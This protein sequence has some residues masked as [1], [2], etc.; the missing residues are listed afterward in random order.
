MSRIF[1]RPMFKRGGS[2]GQGITSGLAPTQRLGFKDGLSTQQRLLGAVGQRP[3]GIYDFLTDWG[4]RMASATPK[5]NVLQTAAAEAIEPYEKFVKGKQGEE[6]LLRQVAL[7]AEGIDIKAEQ[8]ALAAEAEANLKRELLKTRGEQQKELYEIEKGENL[9]AL[10]QARAAENIAEGV[11][12]N[13]AHSK[14]EAEWTYIGSK[15]YT[16]RN[17]GGVLSMEQA[18]SGKAQSKFAKKQGKKNGVGTIYFDPYGN[19]VLEIAR[20]DGEY[21][22]IPVVDASE[23]TVIEGTVTEGD[24]GEIKSKDFTSRVKANEY[25]K[26]KGNKISMKITT[27]LTEVDVND[28]AVIFDEAAKVGITIIPSP[29]TLGRRTHVKTFH[30]SANE[31]TK[32]AFQKLLEK[33]QREQKYELLASVG[34]TNRQYIAKHGLNNILRR[35]AD[36][37]KKNSIQIVE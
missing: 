27:D 17:I 32:H 29:T 1:S 9:E 13:Y 21:S 35:Y 31:M 25:K 10:V 4:L 15:K 16:D 30:V 3:S 28:D 20:V 24:A 37:I 23:D 12:N 5:G 8:S 6:N 34:I 33:R 19:R 18:T 11:F 2:A 14:N 7:E 22:L 36:K 26:I